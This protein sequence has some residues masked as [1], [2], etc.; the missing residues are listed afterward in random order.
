LE[1]FQT[2]SFQGFLMFIKMFRLTLFAAAAIAVVVLMP[3]SA[4]AA[5]MYFKAKPSAQQQEARERNRLFGEGL[6]RWQQQ[7]KAQGQ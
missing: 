6:Q 1:R 4:Y 2:D 5:T 7:R 3:E